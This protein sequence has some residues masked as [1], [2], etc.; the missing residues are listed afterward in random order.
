MAPPELPGHTPVLDLVEPV[1]PGLFV[2]LWDDYQLLGADGIAGPLGDVL[3][4]NIPLG[5]QEGLDDVIRAGAQTKSHF[6]GALTSDQTHFFEIIVYCVSAVESHLSCVLASQVVDGSLLSEDV[7]DL[8]AVSLAAVVIVVI[9]G[10]GDLDCSCA[11]L[12]VYQ[13][14][15]S[16]NFHYSVLDEGMLTLQSY[17]VLCKL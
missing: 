2:V 7:D 1:E 16:N 14:T 15:I 5:L 11:E 9:V 12:G 10:G 6:V 8:Q 13:L 3:A 4:V 17:Q